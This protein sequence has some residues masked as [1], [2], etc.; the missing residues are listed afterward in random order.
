MGVTKTAEVAAEI[1][2]G[3]ETTD[4]MIAEVSEV[5]REIASW[6]RINKDITEG[7]TI[8]ENTTFN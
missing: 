2:D 6:V 8:G 4:I 7:E 3:E 1:M 5:S